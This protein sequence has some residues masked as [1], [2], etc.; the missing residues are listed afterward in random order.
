[1]TA[2]TETL[3]LTISEI[4]EL[5]PR[6]RAFRLRAT[7]G[8]ELPLVSAGSHIAIKVQ[9]AN[10]KND[11]RH[12]SL[13]NNPLQ[14]DYY[15]IAVLRESPGRGGS[16]F[17]FENLKEDMQVESGIPTNNFHLH[18]DASPAILIAGGIGI[19]PIMS[20][21]YTLASRGRRFQ[22]HYAGR[23]KNEMA[24]ADDLQQQ[25]ATKVHLYPAD[26]H[27]RM[28]IMN[29]LADAPGNTL[30]YACGPQKM[31]DDIEI[32]ARLL[33]IAKDRIQT[34]HFAADDA[35]KNRELLLELAYSN[36]LIKVAA[37]QPLLNAVRNAGI[38]AAFD[39]CV[40]DCGTCAVKILEGEAEHRDHVLSDAQKADGM[41]CLCVS[42]AK[43]DKLVIAL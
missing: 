12:Y 16:H 13:C 21:A 43:G 26:E 1:M 29:L 22:L 9:L 30:F 33:G 24:F 10:G 28:D 11:I 8:Q 4:R 23:S 40:G 35:D 25:F 3:T 14:R 18:A 41:I 15:E 27:A 38:N 19:T 32:S 34:E 31:L 2:A 7:S 36:K 6:I 20:I 5:T 42:R 39:C 17:I 37:D